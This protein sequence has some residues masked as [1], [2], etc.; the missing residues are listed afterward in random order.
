[1]KNIKLSKTLLFILVGGI[2]PLAFVYIVTGNRLKFIG[3]GII[4]GLTLALFII[5]CAATVGYRFQKLNKQEKITNALL[6]TI[7][8]TII[9]VVLYFT[10][11]KPEKVDIMNFLTTGYYGVVAS[12]IAIYVR[13]DEEEPQEIKHKYYTENK[14]KK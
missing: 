10:L 8:Y 11:L 6:G 7:I 9:Y 13:D 4:L 5:V 2:I 12:I 1:M 3:S 14:K